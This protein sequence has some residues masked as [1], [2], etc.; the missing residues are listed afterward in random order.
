MRGLDVLRVAR[1]HW[2]MKVIHSWI[3]GVPD[4][5][6]NLGHWETAEIRDDVFLFFIIV[7]KSRLRTKEISGLNSPSITQSWRSH[8]IPCGADR[9]GI[10]QMPAYKKMYISRN[11]V[12][13]QRSSMS[14]PYFSS[15]FSPSHV[16]SRVRSFTETLKYAPVPILRSGSSRHILYHLLW[17]ILTC[18]DAT[19][20]KTQPLWKCHSWQ[21]L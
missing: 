5:S 7:T 21:C 18:H 14:I 4:R 20:L 19:M 10:S 6:S 12:G 16:V 17:F 2:K 13:I 3:T 11:C 15:L 1:L 8:H 9:Y